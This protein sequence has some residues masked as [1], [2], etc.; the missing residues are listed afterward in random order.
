MDINQ[1]IIDKSYLEYQKTKHIIKTILEK[2]VLSENP[3]IAL[4]KKKELIETLF[5]TEELRE[6]PKPL[7]LAYY[8][9]TQDMQLL[10]S[11]RKKY[12]L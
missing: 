6:L 10:I 2:I 3:K 12:K 11:D 9:A 8:E 7:G 4:S 5:T 1:V